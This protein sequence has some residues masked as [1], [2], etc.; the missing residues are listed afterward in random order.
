M[1]CTVYKQY[2][3]VG[4]W[5]MVRI[6]TLEYRNNYLWKWFESNDIHYIYNVYVLKPNCAHTQTKVELSNKCHYYV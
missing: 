1:L 5:C 4:L 6:K 2:A 3:H